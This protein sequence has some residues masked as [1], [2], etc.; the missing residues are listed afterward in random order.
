MNI[1]NEGRRKGAMTSRLRREATPDVGF[2]SRRGNEEFAKR[3]EAAGGRRFDEEGMVVKLKGDKD[4]R[5]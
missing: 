2:S 3:M 4:D 5:S 1:T